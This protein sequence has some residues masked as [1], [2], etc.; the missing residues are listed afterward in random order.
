M[1][2][3]E[4]KEKVVGS[5]FRGPFLVGLFIFSIVL[6]PMMITGTLILPLNDWLPLSEPIKAAHWVIYGALAGLLIAA[7]LSI[8]FARSVSPEHRGN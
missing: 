5:A 2:K 6:V 4:T 3:K 8:F 1:A 7:V